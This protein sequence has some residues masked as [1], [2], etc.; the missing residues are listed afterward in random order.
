MRLLPNCPR[1]PYLGAPVLAGAILIA[2]AVSAQQPAADAEWPSFMA[3]HDLAWDRLPTRWGEAAFVGNGRLGATIDY[4]E[5]ALGWTI[6]RTDFVQDQS[7]Y[8]VGRVLLKTA[9]AVTGGT[10]RLAL[11]DAEA[12][13]TV[14]TDRGEV[15]WR[16]FV[17]S[18]PS[19]IVV[20]LDGRGGERAPDLGWAPAEARPPRKVARKE[21][22]A[23]EDLHPPAGVTTNAG[24]I[25]SVQTFLNG[26]AH[27]E[28]IRRG[29]TTST[30]NG[31][32]RVFYVSIDH[33]ATGPAAL[34]EARATTDSAAARG[35]AALTSAHRAWW[36]AYYPASFVSF[37]DPRLESYYWI[38]VYKLGASMREDG[39]ILDLAGPWYRDTPWPAI[40]W[41]LNTQLTYSPL[42]RANRFGLAESL[43]RHLDR[44]RQ[45]LVNNVPE[46]LRGEAAAIGRSSGP[47][48]VRRVDLATATSDAAH[49]AG[50]LP[51]VM[52]L[53]WQHYRSQMDDRALRERVY[54]LLR[55]AIG[56]YLAYVEK[57]ADGRWHLPKTHSPELATVPDANYD[58]SLLRWGLETLIASAQRLGVNDPL[59]PRWRDVLTNLTPFPQDSTGLL[60]GRDRP[61][62]ES[63]RHYSHLLA[64]YP[65]GLI[66]P[67]SQRALFETSLRTW[68]SQPSAFRGYSFTGGA[69]MHAWLGH[70]DAALERLNKYL[71]APRYMEPNTFYAEAGP[72]IETPYSALTS[73]QELFLQDWG[74]ALRVFPAVPGAWKDAAFDRLRTDGAFLV[75]AVRK[76]GRT[77]WV[78]VESLAGSPCR[79]VVPGWA[80]FVIRARSGSVHV[81][82]SAA[83]P[84]ELACEMA[85]GSWMV[86]APDETSPLPPLEPVARPAAPRNPW[87]ALPRD[88]APAAARPTGPQDA[89]DMAWWRQSMQTRDQRVAWW[90][91]ARF[92]MFIHWGVYSRLGGMWNGQ[93]VPGYAEHIQR[94]RQI[95]AAVYRDS[96][97][98]RFNPVRFDADAWMRTAKRAGMGYM[99]I[100]AKHHDGFA[101]YDSRVSDYNIVKATP[102]K[103]DPMRELRDAARH[104]GV[105]FGFYYSHAFDWGDP[106]APGN[107]WEYD[108]PGGDRN[109]HGG[110]EWWVQSPQLLEKARRYVDRKAI[111]QVRELI[112]RY[113]PDILWFDTPHKLPPEENLRV[114]RAAREA[115]PTLVIN[116]RVVQPVPDGPPGSFGDYVN[117]ADRPAEL[118]HPAG[119]WE[120]IPTTNESY[121]WHR[122]DSTHKPPEHFVRLLAKAAARGGNLLLNVG[123]MGDGRIDPRDT[124]ILAG[125]GRWMATNGVSIRG[126]ARI[127]LPVQAWG[128]ATR[129]GNRVYLHVFDWPRDGRLRVAGLQSDVFRASLLA[130]PDAPLAVRRVS[131]ADVEIAVPAEA[132]DAW[133]SVIVLDCGV[134]IEVDSGLYVADAAPTRLHVFDGRL[135]GPGIVYS[136][137]KRNND[138]AI[139]WADTSSAVEW[140]V[141]VERRARYRVSLE[142]GSAARP[143]SA[144]RFEV[145]LGGQRLAGRVVPTEGG[146]TFAVRDVGEVVLQPGHHTIRVR[147]TDA[148]P[149][150][151]M[152]LR[153]LVLAPT[154][155]RE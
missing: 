53:Y 5:G 130:R 66:R 58:L 137:G 92:G 62:K 133:D 60:V 6:N 64:L 120:A 51:W 18:T 42:F 153:R 110:R 116:S 21:A 78:R 22:F 86:L 87:P 24:G 13:G 109:L 151:L 139:R 11:W 105:R 70:G 94:I 80:G 12:S 1:T 46:R 47:D 103:R 15:R 98:A 16:S 37:P 128:E 108:N 52:F 91:E 38:N 10:A 113:D 44:N 25:S 31:V 125:V 33:A 147:R 138:V 142:Y 71:D 9:G 124:L 141:R 20:V 50:N 56:N 136:D 154:P 123:P 17:S 43:F 74:G 49:E 96:A 119:D 7:R 150:E 97:V 2:S 144:G 99:I 155:A 101:M 88:S 59:L 132:P 114:L 81:S 146:S 61:W 8:P 54:P 69:A 40:W 14:V 95:P 45:A 107:D 41:N 102:W 140:T 149:G 23:P 129:Q 135:V 68:E 117:T 152:R 73:I 75:S 143:D 36:H 112:A 28:S 77:A 65:L 106:E 4:Q 3:R 121:G 115:K 82:V 29:A 83:R 100:T 48:L 127:P 32:T 76:D 67:D 84:G 90:R 131:P 79:L 111:P 57:G 89:P 104:H 126:T 34:A 39:P 19:A 26:G 93:R 134:P 72:V 35:L 30:T 63:H 55:L 118:T 27:A 85:K 122:A 148:G 145:T